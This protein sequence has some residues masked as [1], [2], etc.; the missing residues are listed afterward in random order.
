MAPGSLPSMPLTEVL[1]YVLICCTSFLSD[2]RVIHETRRCKW[3]TNTTA[4][5]DSETFALPGVPRQHPGVFLTTTGRSV[6]RIAPRR[7]CRRI[8][9]RVR[10]IAHARAP[11]NAGP[12]CLGGRKSIGE[13]LTI[14]SAVSFRSPE[15][16]AAQSSHGRWDAAGPPIR[17]F[18][19]SV[20]PCAPSWH[21]W[22]LCI[23]GRVP[24]MALPA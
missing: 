23:W 7:L 22:P 5:N 13:S 15:A 21:V 3:H 20:L 24:R 2:G 17:R 4:A 6:R 8:P 1:V 18:I 19:V 9:A 14:T 11:V 10:R 12:K 16:D